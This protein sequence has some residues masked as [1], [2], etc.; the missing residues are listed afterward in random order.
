MGSFRE[1]MEQIRAEK[2]KHAG[3]QTDPA[4]LEQHR[5][6][7]ERWIDAVCDALR[8]ELLLYA[9]QGRVLCNTERVWRTDLRG[10][11]ALISERT[12][13]PFYTTRWMFRCEI[14]FESA[15]SVYDPRECV[16]R[17]GET[18]TVLYMLREIERRLAADG[19]V[20]VIFRERESRSP[21]FG[22]RK[23]RSEAV[24]A[25]LCREE[26]CRELKR[27]AEDYQNGLGEAKCSVY[28]G[29]DFAC[30]ID[31]N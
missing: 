1:E 23:E 16:F 25:A 3:R 14:D 11:E 8:R 4:V 18:D 2:R 21:L 27:A 5:L 22:R 24:P 6:D 30:F 15:D 29:S 28:T 9:G 10:E 17:V 26:V 12:W 19:I 20:P 31:E 13:A 7:C